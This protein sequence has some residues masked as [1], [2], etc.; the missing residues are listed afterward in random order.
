MESPPLH[1][2]HQLSKKSFWRYVTPNLD[3]N[4]AAGMPIYC[5]RA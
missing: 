3:A 4:H 1:F 5:R 2:R